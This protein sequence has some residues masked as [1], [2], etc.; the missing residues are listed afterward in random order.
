MRG[1]QLYFRCLSRLVLQDLFP[2]EL[3]PQGQ[4]EDAG[5]ACTDA[6]DRLNAMRVCLSGGSSR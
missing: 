2:A 1:P 5:E 4:F 3:H 6:L